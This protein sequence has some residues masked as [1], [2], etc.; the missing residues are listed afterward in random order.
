MDSAGWWK[1]QIIG[2]RKYTDTHPDDYHEVRYED[3][4]LETEATL[5]RLFRFLNVEDESRSL[6]QRYNEATNG[7]GLV[8]SRIGQWKTEFTAEEKK[9]FWDLAGDLLSDLGYSGEVS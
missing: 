6:L 3:L 5:K 4:L 8:K 2:A 7:I 9:R 1:S